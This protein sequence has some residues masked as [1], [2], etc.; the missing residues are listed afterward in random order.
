MSAR[1]G[2]F[3]FRRPLSDATEPR[4]IAESGIGKT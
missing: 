3:A 2:G 4:N 1:P